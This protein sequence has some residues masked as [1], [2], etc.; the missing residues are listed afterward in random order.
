MWNTLELKSFDLLQVIDIKIKIVVFHSLDI[1]FLF[2]KCVFMLM[3]ELLM[4]VRDV[5]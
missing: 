5:G 1:I 3:G 2:L 4:E